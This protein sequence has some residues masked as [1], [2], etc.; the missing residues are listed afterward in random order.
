MKNKNDY[1][2]EFIDL[3][4]REN[5]KFMFFRLPKNLQNDIYNTY[6]KERGN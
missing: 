2:K 5:I 1:P 4:E 6:L 3:L